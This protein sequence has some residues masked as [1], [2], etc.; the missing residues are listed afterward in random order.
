MVGLSCFASADGVGIQHLSFKRTSQIYTSFSESDM[1]GW[2][3]VSSQKTRWLGD[4]R[5]A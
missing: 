3:C 1:A 5:A 2:S 4:E